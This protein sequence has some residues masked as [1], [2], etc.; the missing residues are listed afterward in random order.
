MEKIKLFC[1]PY[2]GG[3]SMIYMKWKRCLYP[4]IMLVPIEL[5]GRGQRINEE[6][7]HDFDNM[8]DDIVC[9][10]LQELDRETKFSILGHSMGCLL[11][12]E[13]YYRLKTLGYSASHMFFLG[14]HV[15]HEM[16]N[17]ELIDLNSE[18]VLLNRLTVYGGDT[19]EILQDEELRDIFLP[20]IRS[21]FEVLQSYQFIPKDEKIL[22]DCTILNGTEDL[23]IVD[24]N[25]E[26]WKGYVNT[27]CF[28]WKYS[29]WPFF[30]SR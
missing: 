3:S 25:I 7:Y 2:A 16:N 11:A 1:L 5:A 10:V 8:L 15:P 30:Y 20:I 21:D 9:N 14:N 12:Y 27:E 23:S 18:L 6:C 22:C 19:L 24:Y 26:D 29:G 28:F 4:N 17:K 13:L